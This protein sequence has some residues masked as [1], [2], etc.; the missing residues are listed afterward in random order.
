MISPP[1]KRT[2]QNRRRMINYSIVYDDTLLAGYEVKNPITGHNYAYRMRVKKKDWEKV[3]KTLKEM[4]LG[5]ALITIPLNCFYIWWAFGF[6][7]VLWSLGHG[8]VITEVAAGYVDKHQ[9]EYTA[10]QLRNIQAR[11]R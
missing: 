10:E 3:D 2:Y 1:A 8:V 4:F 7:A 11:G 5:Q 9:K 6:P